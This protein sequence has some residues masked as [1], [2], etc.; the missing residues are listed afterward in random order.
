[1]IVAPGF[2]WTAPKQP[3]HIRCL[4]LKFGPP[5]WAELS[6]LAMFKKSLKQLLKGSTP[7]SCKHPSVATHRS[8]A[9]STVFADK[10]PSSKNTSSLDKTLR[11]SK[12]RK[13]N[14]KRK[15]QEPSVRPGRG[16]KNCDL[17]CCIQVLPNKRL[18]ASKVKPVTLGR[19]QHAVRKLELWALKH[20]R[21]LSSSSADATIVTYL[22]ELCE[23]S[24][25]IVDARSTVYGFIMLR[26]ESSLPEHMLLGQSKA[27][28]RGWSSRFPVHSKAGVDLRI[29]DVVAFQCL[30]NNDPLV[31]A[32]I[33][34]QGDTYTRPSEILGIT[35]KSI[36]R[37][38]KSRSMYWGLVL[39]RQEDA[40]PTKTGDY[41][42]CVLLDST[43][44]QD[45]GV[46]LKFLLHRHRG[47]ADA[48]SLFSP[49]TLHAY[50]TAIKDA[51]KQLDLHKLKLTPCAETFRP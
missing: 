6:D 7:G 22:H 48:L 18:R 28:L 10:Y 25:S 4:W 47:Q 9:S 46:V 49:L 23:Q 24:G 44:R 45:L 2:R 20:H 19:Y 11:Q 26:I 42:D 30:Q 41:D 17:S 43:G 12:H 50:N 33:L 15:Q 31:C 3:V 37:P 38:H 8:S 13:G 32:A 21:S 29:W 40:V 35:P 14:G 51:C 1:M 34:L 5:F 16:C 27:A 39:S 36:I